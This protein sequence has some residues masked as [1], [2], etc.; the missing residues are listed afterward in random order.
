MANNT[1]TGTL[2]GTLTDIER[3]LLSKKIEDSTAIYK[4]IIYIFYVL[5]I[6]SIIGVLLIGYAIKAS[7]VS[8][9]LVIGTILLINIIIT[10]AFYILIGNIKKQRLATLQRPE[11]KVYQVTCLLKRTRGVGIYVGIFAYLYTNLYIYTI[12]NKI[13]PGEV[14]PKNSKS[15]IQDH[16]NQIVTFQYIPE[17]SKNRLYTD[18]NGKGYN[19]ITDTYIG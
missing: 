4:K 13:I 3:T 14:L 10:P 2:V 1:E 11:I 12:D 15:K 19:F 18:Q 8:D 17:I 16:L 7:I 6:L 5:S 9:L